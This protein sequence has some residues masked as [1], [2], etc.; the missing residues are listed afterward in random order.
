MPFVG[1]QRGKDLFDKKVKPEKVGD[2]CAIAYTLIVRM[3]RGQPRWTTAHN[4][5]KT[6]P[7]VLL[8]VTTYIPKLPTQLTGGDY[9]T[10]VELAW[11]VFFS[12]HVM[13]YERK[14][15]A[16]NGDIE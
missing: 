4:I 11:D 10:A 15:L 6:L 3:W 2:L 7:S 1:T 5:K 13:D 8:E 14:K 12:I 16:E 9:V